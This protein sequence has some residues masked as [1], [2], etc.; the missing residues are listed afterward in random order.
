[1]SPTLKIYYYRI[2]EKYH[3]TTSDS[4]DIKGKE[5]NYSKWEYSIFANP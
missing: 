5:M 1:M 4:V 2:I 3:F